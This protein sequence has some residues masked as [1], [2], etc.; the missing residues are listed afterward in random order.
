[1]GHTNEFVWIRKQGETSWTRFESYKT[2]DGTDTAPTYSGNT[3]VRKEFNS[4][5]INSIY[6]RVDNVFPGDSTYQYRTHKCIVYISDAIAANNT[7]ITYEYVVGRSTKGE[8]PRM[9]IFQIYKHLLCI[10]GIISL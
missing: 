6:A 8:N 5:V 7:P 9:A 2:G 4:T 1:M 3:L 10:L